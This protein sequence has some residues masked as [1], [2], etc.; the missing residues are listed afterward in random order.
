MKVGQLKRLIELSDLG[1]DDVIGIRI[2]TFDEKGNPH[3]AG[4]KI[5]GI[6]DTTNFGE[7]EIVGT[8]FSDDESLWN[9]KIDWDKSLQQMEKSQD[10]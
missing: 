8:V 3:H 2:V 4:F 7:W 6:D 1:D 10:E 9:P 5:C